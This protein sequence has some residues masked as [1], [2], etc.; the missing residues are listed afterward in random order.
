MKVV[1]T[2]SKKSS[3]LFVTIHLQIYYSATSDILDI[4][5]DKRYKTRLGK[6][7]TITIM[8]KLC[9][10]ELIQAKIHIQSLFTIFLDLLPELLLLALCKKEIISRKVN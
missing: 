5:K 9:Y 8:E 6:L 4:R 1:L 7:K 2:R 10:Y 3:Y